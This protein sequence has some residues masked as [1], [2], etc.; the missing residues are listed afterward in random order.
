MKHLPRLP[1]L[2]GLLALSLC[3]CSEVDTERLARIWHKVGLHVQAL[4]V[5]AQHRLSS[6]W[7]AFKDRSDSP[8]ALRD[9]ITARLRLDKSLAESS[10]EI[11]VSGATVTLRGELE[12]GAARQRAV[13]LAQTTV[14]VEQVVD[15]LG[16]KE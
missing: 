14:G 16:P 10:I 6:G 3:G 11:D 1:W 5:G 13:E 15:E 9:R 7:S 2:C 12:N 8:A 4:T